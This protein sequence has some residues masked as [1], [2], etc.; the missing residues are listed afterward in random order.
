MTTLL[1]SREIL[2]APLPDLRRALNKTRSS[3][4]K[5]LHFV[6]HIEH[7]RSFEHEVE[8]AFE[9]HR[10]RTNA[11]HPAPTN[12]PLDPIH[13]EFFQVADEHGLQ[14]RFCQHVGQILSAV[15]QSENIGLCFAD[16]QAAS[17]HTS[18]I[19]DLGIIDKRSNLYVVGE[20]KVPW[21]KSHSLSK[22]VGKYHLGDQLYLRHCLG[23]YSQPFLKIDPQTH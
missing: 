4:L 20:M 6:G 18:N 2:E 1:T 23:M 17:L 15:F 19:P 3:A 9:R 7:W 8:E 11:F 10:F 5:D 16:A 12:N 14:G 21:I 13:N 22:A